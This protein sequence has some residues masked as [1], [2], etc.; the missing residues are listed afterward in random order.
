MTFLSVMRKFKWVYLLLVLFLISCGNRSDNKLNAVKDNTDDDH[1]LVLITGDTLKTKVPLKLEGKKTLINESGVIKTKLK[2]PPKIVKSKNSPEKIKS[3]ETTLI[4]LNQKLK[5]RGTIDIS[6]LKD[7]IL[8]GNKSTVFFPKPVQS[9]KPL[10]R[11]NAI[12]D[13]QWMDVDQGLN[14][15][16]VVYSFEDSRNNIWI[17]Y[18]GGGVSK[19]DG[20]EF[21]H[22]T[23]KEGLFNNYVWTI[24]EDS[25][26]NLWFGHYSGGVTK[27]DG[28]AFTH[29]SDEDGFPDRTIWSILEDSAGNMWFG[30]ANGVVKFNGEIFTHYTKGAGLIGNDVVSM[31]EDQ[32]KNIWFA[33]KNSGISIY[34]GESFYSLTK[35]DGLPDNRVLSVYEATNK[36]IWIGTHGGACKYDGRSLEKITVKEGLTHNKVI[37]IVEDKNNNIWIGTHGG[38][39][40][41]YD[42]KTIYN[43]TKDEGLPHNEIRHLLVDSKG[44]IWGGTEGAGLFKFNPNSF[45][46]YTKEQGLSTEQ[47]FSMYEDKKGTIWFGTYGGGLTKYDG[48]HFFHYGEEQ[49]LI[50]KQVISLTEDSKGNLWFGTFSQGL[51]KFDGEVFTQYN[52]DSGLSE[53]MVWSVVED[54]EGTMW[55][56]TE[57]GGLNRFDG[58][59]F[60]NYNFGEGFSSYIVW[61][62]LEDTKGNVWIATNRGGIC[63]YKDGEF[64]FYAQKEGLLSDIVW[65]ILE[66]KKG[67]IWFG[68]HKGICVYDGKT[69]K[70]FNEDDGLSNNIVWSLLQDDKENIWMGTSKGLNCLVLDEA[71]IA[72][73]DDKEKTDAINGYI[74]SFQKNDG[75]K[76]TIFYANSSLFDKNHNM[77]FGT[78]SGVVNFNLNSFNLVDAAPSIQLNTIDINQKSINYNLLSDSIYNTS[79]PFFNKIKDCAAEVENFHNYPKRLELPFK[80]NHLTFKFAGIDWSAPHSIQYSYKISGLDKEWS[81]P[82][83]ENKADYRNIPPGTYMFNVRA[84][85]KSGQWSK[86]L[87]YEFS[88]SPPW[89]LS[90][91]AINSY[92]VLSILLIIGSF[93][94]YGNRMKKKQVILEHIVE[95][96]TRTIGHQKEELSIA[97]ADLEQERN[98]MELKALLNQINPHFIF[99]ALNSIQQFVIS[100]NVKTSLDYFNKFGKLIR[101]SLE[102]SEMKFVS[103]NDEVQV[104]R[105]Y[106]DLENLRFNEPVVLN[107][108]VNHIDAYN[109]KIPPMF[110]QPIVENAII[111]GLSKKEK[112]KE[113]NINFEEFDDYILCSIHDNGSGRKNK[114]SIKNKNSGMIIT[115]KRLKSVWNLSDEKYIKVVVEDLKDPTGTIVKIKLP[116]DF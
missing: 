99:N 57:M 91:W 22:F 90:F 62:I 70:S 86:P 27:Y 14:S 4:S 8:E 61:D 63:K 82:S 34:N 3:T 54:R 28:K 35:D 108:E 51:F 48:A 72:K 58:K 29:Y 12:L 96:R 20:V 94:W 102:H 50:A 97:Y 60:I 68:T 39:V 47:I 75:L 74:T 7:T 104:I 78:I 87:Q 79:T 71:L 92:I 69:I 105:N 6:K 21:L 49:G 44:N 5:Q 77:W 110:I 9:E 100:N 23:E 95:E 88:I 76:S 26:H 67:N 116:K 98:K 65:T 52:K 81:I 115:Q 66:D 37:S 42:G 109:V 31:I 89:W 53:N 80:F 13:I 10:Y 73:V 41:R 2:K 85:G 1:Y 103:I 64:T 40:S 59:A 55:V 24:Y 11:D 107:C 84:I 16:Y 19:F 15:S 101:A 32:N 46:H 33:T 25:K 56:G 43:I 93:K 38:G 36:D 111:H 18:Y 30:T 83:S 17:G 114:K 112:E 113:I 106:V 45:L